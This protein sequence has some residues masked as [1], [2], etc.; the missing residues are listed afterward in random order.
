MTTI[1]FPEDTKSTID[2]IRD[3]IGRPVEWHTV[4][5]SGCS[6]CELDPINNTSTDSFCPV[7]FPA[8]TLIK[9]KSGYEQI[10]DIKIGTKVQTVEGNYKKVINRFERETDKLL[11]VRTSKLMHGLLLTPNHKVYILKPSITYSTNNCRTHWLTCNI[12]WCKKHKE[13]QKS[14]EKDIKRAEDL[15]IGDVLIVPKPIY[16]DLGYHV[17]IPHFEVKR[18]A[19]TTQIPTKMKL[20][21]ELMGVFGWYLAEG[22]AKKRTVTFTLSIDEEDVADFIIDTLRTELGFEATK[23]INKSSNVIIVSL[24]GQKIVKFFRWLFPGN[25]YSKEINPLILNRNKSLLKYLLL[26]FFAGDGHERRL[27]EKTAVTVSR[28]LAYQLFDIANYL[29][30]LPSISFKKGRMDKNFVNHQA[31]YTISFYEA[32]ES[33]R[34]C[35]QDTD[36]LY[37]VI[38][39]IKE[40]DKQDKVYNIE[41]EDDHNYCA[42]LYA[43]ENCSGI[44]WIPTYEVTTISGHI[45]WGF[46]EQLGW[47]SGGQLA[48]GECRVQIK[49]TVANLGVVENAKKIFVDGKEMQIEKKTLR[50]VKNINRI[51]IDLIEK[52]S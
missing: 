12:P 51:L 18:E 13:Q 45:T 2:S 33:N 24:Y 44:Y 19:S 32:S 52:E 14:V 25:V 30:Y 40:I 36:N 28:I 31:F 47:V 37:I 34:L 43:V 6:I 48:E 22:G 49:Y 20:T 1:I 11:L 41:V 9:T 50:G 15:I 5:L 23:K 7:C 21:P 39:S 4:T 16:K 46:S 3:A 17:N 35:W 27:G 10:E 29:D 42:D 38:K 8:G 26:G